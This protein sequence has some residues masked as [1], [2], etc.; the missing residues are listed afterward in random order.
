MFWR[1]EIMH[2]EDWGYGISTETII[3]SEG[4]LDISHGDGLGNGFSG[5]IS[6][7]WTDR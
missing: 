4:F 1:L 5:G 3:S 2:E 6:D 7:G